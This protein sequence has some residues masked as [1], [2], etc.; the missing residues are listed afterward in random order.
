MVWFIFLDD[1][2]DHATDIKESHSETDKKSM[3]IFLLA[4][5][6]LLVK[7][8]AYPFA[9]CPAEK[10]HKLNQFTDIEELNRNLGSYQQFISLIHK[11]AEQLFTH[12]INKLS[13]AICCYP[14]HAIASYGHILCP[15]EIDQT[16]IDCN[17]INTR[18][19]D[20]FYEHRAVMRQELAL[21][22]NDDPMA[23]IGLEV[24]PMHKINQ[25]MLPR[26]QTISAKMERL[27]DAETTTALAIFDAETGR[28]KEECELL[29]STL[30]KDQ[31]EFKQASFIENCLREK[32]LAARAEHL[33]KYHDRLDHAP[34]LAYMEKSTPTREEFAA[35]LVELRQNALNHQ[36]RFKKAFANLSADGKGKLDNAS[37]RDLT[38]L[39]AARRVV[40]KVITENPNFCTIADE[41]SKKIK[42][43]EILKTS[44]WVAATIATGALSAGAS[45]VGRGV[46]AAGALAT[47]TRTAPLLYSHWLDY[48]QASEEAFS[49]LGDGSVTKT[50]SEAAQAKDNLV[51]GTVEA[52]ALEGAGQVA[53]IKAMQLAKK[54][55]ALN[56]MPLQ[57][58]SPAAQNPQLLREL[59][60]IG[61]QLPTP[62]Q[63]LS[64][65]EKLN[66][67]E[68]V[69]RVAQAWKPERDHIAKIFESYPEGSP[70]REGAKHALEQLNPSKHR[71]DRLV[72]QLRSVT[73]TNEFDLAHLNET[74]LQQIDNLM[75]RVY[76]AR[77]ELEVA[78]RL[79]DVK[80]MNVKIKQLYPKAKEIFQ[81]KKLRPDYSEK[82]IDIVR[83]SGNGRKI[84]LE[85]KLLPHKVTVENLD[86]PLSNGSKSV[87]DQAKEIKEIVGSLSI[88]EKVKA[89]FIF[90]NGIEKK[91]ADQLRRLGVEVIGPVY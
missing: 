53:R 48:S 50:S 56:Q 35:A 82:E 86:K 21:A 28:A 11:D 71:S 6:I 10:C 74:Q 43:D 88:I 77:G 13:E 38:T 79:N 34:F 39:M 7:H 66:A 63:L 81:Q 70:I 54:P 22:F 55:W 27:S 87:L 78:A 1:R 49:H 8:G 62:E 59:E 68:V 91:A 16:K 36:A 14:E 85:T 76:G 64:S 15:H 9:N 18:M 47:A 58:N 41:I 42:Y 60:K 44:A 73:N 29:N 19:T 12:N 65:A 3:R 24:H 31:P 30:R 4:A 72:T 2:R 40:E 25:S 84:F 33:E 26:T 20:L 37:A 52:A 69:R 23:P 5:I 46:F 67:R 51:K 83:E 90:V 32:R 57:P 61:T 45:A 89:Q 75:R 80:Q 17:A